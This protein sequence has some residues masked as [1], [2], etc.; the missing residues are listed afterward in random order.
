MAGAKGGGSWKVAYADFVTAM[1][2]FFLVMWIGAQDQKTRQSVANYFVDPAGTA[3]KPARSGA[4]LNDPAY[5]SVPKE[6]GS[7]LAK[8]RDAATRGGEQ[9]P[10]TRLVADWLAADPK[11]HRDWKEKARACR[12][13]AAASVAV[14]ERSE[15]VEEVAA[16]DLSV[17]LSSTFT[18]GSPVKG[19][20]IYEDLIMYSLK[21]VNWVELA[22]DLLR[23]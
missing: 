16:K 23:H 4:V 7:A 10:A 14:R 8:G 22:E 5:G 1:M 19:N 12:E 3:K 20:E 18:A 11:R 6:E 15:S 2:A 17:R 13:A 9:G 21:E